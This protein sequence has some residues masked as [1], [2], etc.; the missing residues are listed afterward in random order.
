MRGF[1]GRSIRPGVN[2]N[3][4]GGA[5]S[6][7][8]AGECL[9][10]LTRQPLRRAR[11]PKAAAPFLLENYQKDPN[12]ARAADSLLFLAESMVALKDNARACRALAEFA[13]KYAA[14]ATGRLQDQYDKDRQQAAC[15]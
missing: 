4:P 15:K 3:R 12:G 2:Q 6:W 1:P 13:E 7:A 10:A 5:F 9:L 8:A 14:L 11:Q